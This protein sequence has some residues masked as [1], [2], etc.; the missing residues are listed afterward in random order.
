MESKCAIAMLSSKHAPPTVSIWNAARINGLGMKEKEEMKKIID[1]M[2]IRSAK[3]QML[4]VPITDYDRLRSG[5]HQ[6]YLWTMP[7]ASLPNTLVVKGML[8]TGSK[9][10]F[11]RRE[12]NQYSQIAPTCV[13]DFYVHESFQ[14]TGLGRQLFEAMLDNENKQPHQLGSGNVVGFPAKFPSWVPIRTVVP[15]QVKSQGGP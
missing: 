11:I 3:A 12:N 1:E 6:L 2:G 10:L 15:Q 9:N 7:H 13:L 5:S 14:R 4:K 8:K